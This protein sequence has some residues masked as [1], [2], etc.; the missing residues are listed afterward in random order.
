MAG[1]LTLPLIRKCCTFP[2]QLPNYHIILLITYSPGKMIAW[3]LHKWSG[4]NYKCLTMRWISGFSVCAG[5][6]KGESG[7]GLRDT[8]VK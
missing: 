1:Q 6:D 7:K 2:L 3:V 8:K 4:S 5:G